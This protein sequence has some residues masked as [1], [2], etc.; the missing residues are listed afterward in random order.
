LQ[1]LQ[2]GTHMKKQQPKNRYNRRKKFVATAFGEGYD[3]L[4]PQQ[5]IARAQWLA[6]SKEREAQLVAIAGQTLRGYAEAELSDAALDALCK[7]GR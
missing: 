3:S 4:T 1:I 5:R 2:L 6:A 7:P